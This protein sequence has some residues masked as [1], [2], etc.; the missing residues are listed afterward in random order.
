[1]N[2]H[3][4]PALR[5]IEILF[6]PFAHRKLQLK[7]RIVMAPASGQIATGGSIPP[8]I[9]QY[10]RLRAEH[11]IALII[12]EPLATDDP[13]AA[14]SVDSPSFAGGATLRR[15]K[16]IC[17]AVHAFDCKI[18]PQLYHAGLARNAESFNAP[19]AISPVGPSGIHPVSLQQITEP[20]S[21]RRMEEIKA[22][23][24]RAA[25]NAKLLG[26][27]A[28]EIQGSGGFLIDQFLWK[29]TNQ[30]S[31]EYGGSIGGRVRFACE[32]VHAVRKSVGRNF[33]IIFRIAQWKPGH[34]DARL[35]NTAHELGELLHPLSEAGVDIFHCSAT[36][37]ARPALEGNPLTLAAW[38][39]LLTGKP[40]ISAGGIEHPSPPHVR[41][42]D[43]LIRLLHAN[44][45]DLIAIEN[46]LHHDPAWAS[47]LRSGE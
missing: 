29:E 4:V 36:H 35:V 28:V 19:D 30:R 34:Q 37:F 46:A 25:A 27:D 8:A 6:R 9:E 38:V 13:A 15:W 3:L 22:S 18:A 26:F 5:D 10:Y 31:D 42:L 40:T 39:R 32:V 16:S 44:A 43:S 11:D 47:K 41:T 21:R 14:V 2:N 45:F 24:G 23:F 7:G 20:I 17:R 12:S 33:P 1:M